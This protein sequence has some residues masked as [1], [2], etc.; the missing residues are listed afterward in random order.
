MRVASSHL[1]QVSRTSEKTYAG[2][3]RL[4]TQLFRERAAAV[5]KGRIP[6]GVLIEIIS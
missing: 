3:N 4:V 2:S 6:S 1:D 5:S